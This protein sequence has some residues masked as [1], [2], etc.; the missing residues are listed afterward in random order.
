MICSFVLVSGSIKQLAREYG[1]SYPTM[2]GRL[3][4]LIK[5]LQAHM[6]GQESN[7]LSDY[8]AHLIATG[9]MP[10]SAARQ[11]RDLHRTALAA[12]NGTPAHPGAPDTTGTQPDGGPTNA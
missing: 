6:Q 5:R 11:V 2:R 8:L 10:R 12:A 3:D 7:P 9:Q 4:A 1:V